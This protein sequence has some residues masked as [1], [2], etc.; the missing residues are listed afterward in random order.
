MHNSASIRLR[1]RGEG[2]RGTLSAAANSDQLQSDSMTSVTKSRTPASDDS[3]TDR[4][5]VTRVQHGERAAFDLLVIRY[6]SRV[7]SIISR[8]IHDSQDVL[9]LTQES[10][11]KAYRAITRF[12]GESAFYTW[13][14]RIA[15]NT[16][17]N[18][19]ESR[20]RRP[21][22]VME[23]DDAEQ[24]DS[25]PGLRELGSPEKQMQRDQLQRAIDTA[26]GELPEELRS[27]LL[28]REFEGLSYED[29]A[30]VLECPIGTVRSRIFR[31]RDAI[32]RH[33]APLIEA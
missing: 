26:L 10:F 4:Q 15:V 20:G 25:A 18:H 21:Q 16:A 32:D 19:L 6:Q 17:K 3:Q 8:Y 1:L 2:V 28:L 33:I 22:T 27:A 11:V 5:L 30:K 23:V 14:Y 9:D 13:L 7:A 24:L 12:R 29:I 31:A